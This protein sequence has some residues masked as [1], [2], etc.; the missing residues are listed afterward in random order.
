MPLGP[1]VKPPSRRDAFGVVAV[2]VALVPGPTASTNPRPYPR[3]PLTCENIHT[4]PPEIPSPRIWKAWPPRLPDQ[5][6]RPSGVERGV[7]DQDRHS[8]LLLDRAIVYLLLRFGCRKRFPPPS[9]WSCGGVGGLWRHP[10]VGFYDR[11]DLPGARLPLRRGRY[12]NRARLFLRGARVEKPGPVDARR[13]AVT[14]SLEFAARGWYS[15][16]L[17]PG[18]RGCAILVLSGARS[19]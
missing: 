12:D 10:N 15:N 4:R 8:G 6:S 13:A 2:L 9:P 1:R 3:S 16:M 11:T 7:S 5:P 18:T 17:H 14:R 19:W